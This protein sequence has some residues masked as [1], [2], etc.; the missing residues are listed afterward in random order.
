M[1]IPCCMR[2]CFMLTVALV[3]FAF[4]VG[5]TMAEDIYKRSDGF[6]ADCD[7]PTAREDGTLLDWATEGGD[8][9]YYVLMEEGNLNTLALTIE[10]TGGCQAVPV[11]TKQWPVGRYW[12]H[13]IATDSA[14]Q[15]SRL[16]PGV[17]F[18]LQN[19]RPNPAMP[20]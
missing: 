13:A 2:T 16:S 20:K 14:S 17:P 18:I 7:N 8:V 10:M 11:D 9:T 15:A 12:R 6:T 1:T 4:F 5:T 19:A 3:C